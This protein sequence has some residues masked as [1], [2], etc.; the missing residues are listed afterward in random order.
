MAKI[1]PQGYIYN[2]EP[3]P[4][5]PFWD[6]NQTK[7]G[8]LDVTPTKEQQTIYGT[9]E[10]DAY[11]PVV[12]AG[13]NSSI[14]ENIKPENIKKDVVILGVAGTYD[15]KPV[16]PVI[17]PLNIK[18]TTNTQEFNKSNI[19]GYKPVTVDAVDASID[20]NITA[21]NIKKDVVILGV[22]GTLEPSGPE[23]II[24]SLEIT[25][26][27]EEQ[28]FNNSEIDGYKPI[29]VS[30]VNATIDENI[31]PENIKKDVVILGVTGTLENT[32]GGL[33][34]SYSKD[35][36]FPDVIDFNNAILRNSCFSKLNINK[37]I[38]IKNF[39]FDDIKYV[40]DTPFYNN[41]SYI[42]LRPNNLTYYN[43]T[44]VK[45]EW[46]LSTV[47]DFS[48][49]N[50]LNI[51]S[52][53]KILNLLPTEDFTYRLNFDVYENMSDDEIN[54]ILFTNNN[55]ELYSVSSSN[56]LRESQKAIKQNNGYFNSFVGTLI[57]DNLDSSLLLCE[58]L[59]LTGVEATA[60]NNNNYT[61]Q[62]LV[63]TSITSVPSLRSSNYLR[64]SPI[65]KGVGFIY[66]PDNLVED[67]K[68]ATNWLLFADQI[69]PLSE[70]QGPLE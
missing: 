18:P 3:Y 44:Y 34:D 42:L 17:E 22:T 36:E 19:D 11:V 24:E 7:T 54:K 26:T 41:K 39:R 13:V 56:T 47:T 49:I 53:S 8:R 2:N 28:T 31:K 27:T 14:D 52:S 9:E 30:G 12:V 60:L 38:E 65:G 57:I 35:F 45:A 15:I 63:Y 10:L 43:M 23:P 21:G 58:N 68:V 51:G 4:D 5:N 67:F 32:S 62:N 40:D 20:S 25:P 33:W 46:D 29:T 61:L 6:E 64:N 48:R 16:E 59:I 70:Y 55:F 1:S 66:V 50:I 69:K 37:K